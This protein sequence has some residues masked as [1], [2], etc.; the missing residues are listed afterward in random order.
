MDGFR[1]DVT[2]IGFLDGSINIP[3]AVQA[4]VCNLYGLSG[5]L[6]ALF[7]LFHKLSDIWLFGFI[8]GIHLHGQRNEVSIQQQRLTD[9]RILPILFGR[10]FLLVI[11]RKIDLEIVVGAIKESCTEITLVMLFVATVEQLDVLLV[12][13][14]DKG[15]AVINLIFRD[16]HAPVQIRK[17]RSC[18]FGFGAWTD[19]P[20]ENELGDQIINAEL[21]AHGGGKDI[22]VF[23]HI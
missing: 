18:S 21:K 20:C 15:T 9:D 4:L 1:K 22:H 19:D 8:A 17:Y 10:A 23:F 3:C 13:C 5:D 12:G 7:H 16:W 6:I 14:T 11:T 2:I